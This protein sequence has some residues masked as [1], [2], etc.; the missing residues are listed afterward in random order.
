MDPGAE[1]REGSG[2]WL[3]RHSVALTV[4]AFVAVVV[5]ARADY[6]TGRGWPIWD[7]DGFYAPFYMFV[8]DLARHG[9]LLT[10]NPF[11]NAGSPD[12]A[13]PQVGAFDPI[14]LVFGLVTGAH[15]AGFL[16]Y[17]LAMWS[18]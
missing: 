5:L 17:W 10:W 6:L 7:A 16:L 2:A 8:A 18:L 13:D 12:F 9:Q 3:A 14:V 15:V 11:L 4:L 1:H